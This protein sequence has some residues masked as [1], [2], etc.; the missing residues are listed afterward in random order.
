MPTPAARQGGKLMDADRSC[1]LLAIRYESDEIGQRNRP[2]N[3]FAG[4]EREYFNCSVT[5]R[6]LFS[7]VASFL[8]L[9]WQTTSEQRDD[10]ATCSELCNW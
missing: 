2:K 5:S 10:P 7:T 1:K 8:R 9:N 4:F 3:E 6:V